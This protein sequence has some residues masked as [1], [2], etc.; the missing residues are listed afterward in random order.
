[1]ETDLS[2]GVS[3]KTSDDDFVHTASQ[4]M[5]SLG[6]ITYSSNNTAVATVNA[7]T[8]EVHLEG[9]GTATITA[10]IAASGCYNTASVSYVV[11]VEDDCDDEA[12]TITTEDLDC[13]GI[14]MT[15]TGHTAADGVTYQWYKVGS[16]DETVGTNQDNYTT[17]TAGS[18][19]VIVT[20]SGERHCAKR[21][22]NTVTVEAKGV[23]TATKIVDS[24]YVK[25]GRRTPD[26]ELVQTTSA[27]G[28]F[29]KIGDTKIWDSD[30]SEKTGFGGCGFHL[31]DNGI[32]YLNGMKDNGDAP[33]ELTA[34]DVTLKITAI[35]C[36][37]NA[38]EL[39]ITIHCQAATERKSIAFV[40]DGTDGGTFAE[41][42]AA[43][44][45]ESALFKFLDY[46]DDSK[47]AFDLTAQ[48][49]YSTTNE[50]AIRE[51]FSQFDAILITDDPSTK[52]KGYV[53]AFGTMID[54]RPI[55]SMEAYVSN[56]SNWGSKGVAGN[57][58]SPNPRQYEMRLQ[59]KDHEI[60]SG[61]PAPAAGT[62]VWSETIDGEEYRHVIMVDSTKS[63]YAGV[64][65][66]EQTAGDKKPAL[67][68]FE[69]ED[70]GNLLGLGLILNGTLHA[71][72][73]R[74][75][76]PA[77]RM[78]L[79]GIQNQALPNALTEEG[80]KVIE[81]AL[82]YLLKTNMEE[83]D[84]CSNFFKGGDPTKPR[85]WNTL[86]NW[87]KA[88]FPNYETKVRILAPCEV[89]GIQV[90]VAQVDIA[91]SGTSSKIDGGTCSGS[92]T[93]AADGALIVGGK[94]RTAVAPRF[95][96]NELKPT[97]ASDLKVC[98][99][100]S[101]TGALIFDN[102]DGKT[103]ATV[104]MW[105]P[106]HWET[107]E[108]KKKK[109][110]SYVGVPIANVEIPNYFYLGF[111]YLYDETS[112]W[113]KKWDGDVLQPFEGIGL[114]MQSGN[115][116]TFY[117][118]LASTATKE[119]TL[120]KTAEGGNGENLIGNSWTAPIQIAN[121]ENA[122][123]GEATATVYVYNTGRDEQ[124]SGETGEASYG[125]NSSATAGQWVSVP[126]NVAKEGG[127]TGLKVIPAMNAFQVNTASET[128]L[129]L[130]YD[131]L[132][133]KN[134]ASNEGINSPMRAPRRTAA[135]E[136]DALMRV[137][138]SGEKTHTDVWLLQDERFSEDFDN[139][140][141]AIYAECDNRSAQLYAVSE[142]G[143]MAFIAKPDLDGTPL[144][145]APSRDGNTYS[146][147]FQYT[148]NEALYLNDMQEETSTLINEENTYMFTYSESDMT[149]RFIISAQPF[150]IPAIITGNENINTDAKPIKF[151]RENKMYILV[152]GILYDATGKIVVR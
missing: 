131:K 146:F 10:T 129:T 25:N 20:N 106:S 88:T 137:R 81:N 113:V 122:D 94:V 51:H 85:D 57:P 102:S 23:A 55:L 32:I 100:S 14:K 150:G 125:G 139:G 8:G 87:S 45:T 71:G 108:G 138:V 124:A 78:M 119:I 84:D 16:P 97:T 72:V 128:T 26:V 56:L 4:D 7:T 68:G 66:N 90:R 6:A 37:G 127:Y 11:T 52:T 142:L 3:K 116:E 123:F 41:A 135:K 60:Y 33:T 34:G 22:R 29:V 140:W 18:Y 53:N 110:W 44:S 31:G 89:S 35:G 21:S 69:S 79:L 75:E 92:L 5:N 109:Y 42:N 27:T 49:I 91:T 36:G 145:F 47:G 120:T 143:Q 111:T 59:C 117:G 65:Y 105:N 86:A 114:S 1:W 93:I 76:E 148:G 28:F 118:T 126:V 46:G 48:N 39:S 77:A 82:K 121:F 15:I 30:G 136:I 141:E 104:E 67:Q 74:Q 70:M 99:S 38:S 144:G 107:V 50:K 62:H 115:K 112:G 9:E 133:R 152:N 63:P 101:G 73:E 95:A 134:A 13:S 132:V 24:W 12:G 17:T 58:S 2:G 96:V 130:D 64:A 98:S 147:S 19:Y 149:G 43:H 80:K 61:L 103:Q 151:I 83:V 40:V 54:V